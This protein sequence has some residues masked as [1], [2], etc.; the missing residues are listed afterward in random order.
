MGSRLELQSELETF[1]PNVYFQ[2]PEGF[3]MK[4]PCIVYSKTGKMRNYASDNVYRS[5]QEYT[6]LVIDKNP[7]SEVAD[8]IERHFKHCA[9][10]QYYTV[11]NLNHASLSLYY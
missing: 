6:I 10:N 5:V 11:D 7:D 1:L 8:S 9:I 3:Q 2:P 4:Y